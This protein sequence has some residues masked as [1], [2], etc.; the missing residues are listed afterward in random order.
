MVI[1]ITGVSG[2]GKTTLGRALAAA[3]G[4]PFH[5]ADDL[6]SPEHIA[7]M[8]RGE[9]LTDAQRQPW[10]AR[11]RQ[12]IEAAVHAGTSAVVACSALREPY[13]RTLADGLPDVRFV[14]L[15]VSEDVARARLS[16]RT[17][18]FAGPSL[19][20]S[21][22][23]VLEPPADALT[24]DASLPVDRL[25]QFVRDEWKNVENPEMR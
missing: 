14:F 6:H 1:V 3:L 10:L 24:L 18:H 19:V 23:A 12:V 5:D 7:R 8:S 16:A 4:W 21:Q 15:Q 20:D 22:F 25:V 2:S 11:V 13:R 9:R 17:N